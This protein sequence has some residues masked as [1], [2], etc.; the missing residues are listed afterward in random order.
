MLKI[1]D[2]YLFSQNMYATQINQIASHHSHTKPTYAGVYSADNLPIIEKTNKPW[3]IIANKDPGNSPGSHWVV[4]F[5]NIDGT[6]DYFCSLGEKPDGDILSYLEKS[7]YYHAPTIRYQSNSSSACGYMCLYY[8]DLRS[9]GYDDS[10]TTATLSTKH[11]GQ[12]DRIVK[13]Y[14]FGH[15]LY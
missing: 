6:I 14:V 5:N 7:K 9:I 2:R 1:A 10:T 15:M 3:F 13:T 12:N 4:L 8:A 11:F